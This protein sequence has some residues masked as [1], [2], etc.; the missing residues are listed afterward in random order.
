[1]TKDKAGI[2]YP[3]RTEPGVR[4]EPAAASSPRLSLDFLPVDLSYLGF[5]LADSHLGLVLLRQPTLDGAPNFLVC[6]PVS[7]RHSLLPPLPAAACTD[8]GKFFAPAILS[9]ATGRRFEFDA[10][11]ATVDAERPRA[12]VASFRDSGCSWRALPRSGE[13]WINVDPYWLE[14]RCVHAAGSV[15][16]H[17]CGCQHA[18]ALD[19]A[20]MAFSLM[21]VPDFIW[22][23]LGHP[24]YRVGETPDGRLD[25]W[26]MEREL[27]LRNAL[28]AVPGLA[29]HPLRESEFSYWISDVDPGRTGRVFIR[30]LGCGRFSCHMDT[31]KLESLLTDDGMEYGDP[32]LA[33]FA[34]PNEGSD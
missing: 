26:V 19:A 8:N 2:M 28:N 21:R 32:I 5:S 23:D 4:F 30:T 16:W 29:E 9:H 31:G 22:E 27:C 20:T 10:V 34:V 12:W 7:R 18:L 14:Q 6:D 11:C 3:T 25:G 17:I 1:M 24:K 33:Y 15:Y 13:V